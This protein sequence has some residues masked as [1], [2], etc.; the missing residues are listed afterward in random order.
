MS[1]AVGTGFWL[2][3]TLTSSA[4]EHRYPSSDSGKPQMSKQHL[5]SLRVRLADY[6]IVKN[7]TQSGWP[8]C[9]ILTH[10]QSS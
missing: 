4:T 7:D 3:S 9:E 2:S 1:N 8:D 6:I 5:V 10:A